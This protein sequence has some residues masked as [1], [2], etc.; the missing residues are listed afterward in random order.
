MQTIQ[1][2]HERQD[3]YM[4]QERLSR[5]VKYVNGAREARE[6]EKCDR[7]ACGSM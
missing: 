5:E 4:K 3:R 7:E 1:E 2:K 6:G